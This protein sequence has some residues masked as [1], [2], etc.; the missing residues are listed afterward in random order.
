MWPLHSPATLG[1]TEKN[2]KSVEKLTIS[3]YHNFPACNERRTVSVPFIC[4]FFIVAQCCNIWG[5]AGILPCLTAGLSFS[6]STRPS[7]SFLI[8]LTFPLCLARCQLPHFPVCYSGALL[9]PVPSPEIVSAFSQTGKFPI[10]CSRAGKRRGWGM[11]E[12]KGFGHQRGKLVFFSGQI[13]AL[14]TL[15]SVFPWSLP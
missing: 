12:G 10:I 1:E 3:F 8:S 4:L 5:L 11:Y 13:S 2:I 6:H 15:F 7:L 9:D 14:S